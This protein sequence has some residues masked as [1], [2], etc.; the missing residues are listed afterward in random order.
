MQNPLPF[1]LLAGNLLFEK[2]FFEVALHM[3]E[4]HRTRYG[5]SAGVLHL[6]GKIKLQQHDY[7]SAQVLL[8]IAQGLSPDNLDR[9]CMLGHV[10]LH[11][12]EIE[13]A[14]QYFA[15]ASKMDAENHKVKAGQQLAQNVSS[16]LHASPPQ[17]LPK[18][19]ASL[20]NA[21]GISMVKA[22]DHEKG[23]EHYKNA[24]IYVHDAQL[25]ARLAFNVGLGYARWQKPRESLKWLQKAES[26]YPQF[27]KASLLASKVTEKFG[28]SMSHPVPEPTPE[29]H[30]MKDVHKKEEDMM[31]SL[32]GDAFTYFEYDEIDEDEES[33]Y[34]A[35]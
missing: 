28:L 21:I 24:L 16:Y 22:Q 34:K 29:W 17:T 35:L 12:L 13:E 25:Q 20:L 23:I 3:L 14:Q 27:K 18:N 31:S 1:V 19:F 2:G 4:Q 33:Y 30:A 6:L 8:S 7:E 32:G 26:L 11:Q 15:K 5:D 9:L 10:S